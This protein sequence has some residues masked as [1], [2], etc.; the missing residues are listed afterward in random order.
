M[1][2]VDQFVMTPPPPRKSTI[3]INILKKKPL[4]EDG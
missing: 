2:D 3:F 4:P 1:Q